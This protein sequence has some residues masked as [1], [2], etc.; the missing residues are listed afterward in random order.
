M[1]NSIVDYILKDADDPKNDKLA[2]EWAKQYG[3]YDSFY[4]IIFCWIG[5]F[6]LLLFRKM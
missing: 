1:T 4:L 5:I 2:I 6:F 3:K